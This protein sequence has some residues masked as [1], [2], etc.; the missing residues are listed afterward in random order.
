MSLNIRVKQLSFFNL[1]LHRKQRNK[2]DM[3]TK[4]EGRDARSIW[5]LTLLCLSCPATLEHHYLQTNWAK[6]VTYE[7]ERKPLVSVFFK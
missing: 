2:Q 5:E 7:I 4:C 3:S 6:T 1:L